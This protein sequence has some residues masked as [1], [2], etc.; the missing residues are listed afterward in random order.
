MC[1]G[2]VL[3]EA[4]FFVRIGLIIMTGCAFLYDRA[5]QANPVGCQA[6]IPAR[7][8][9]TN[10]PYSKSWESTCYLW[11]IYSCILYSEWC[12]ILINV[13][14]R[15]TLYWIP[16]S[17]RCVFE[18]KKRRIFLSPGNTVSHLQPRGEQAS[19]SWTKPQSPVPPVSLLKWL[20]DNEVRGEHE[21]KSEQQNVLVAFLQLQI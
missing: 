12:W 19:V 16:R 3:H 1:R 6:L 17:K 21:Q 18:K 11:I 15:V 4:F 14:Q 13:L 10:A 8:L 20:S 9:M 7:Q 2:P 5:Q